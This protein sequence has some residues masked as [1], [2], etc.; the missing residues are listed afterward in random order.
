MGGKQL[1]FHPFIMEEFLGDKNIL[2]NAVTGNRFTQRKP[3]SSLE[4]NSRFHNI[5]TRKNLLGTF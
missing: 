4:Q 5:I 2:F 1:L 3:V